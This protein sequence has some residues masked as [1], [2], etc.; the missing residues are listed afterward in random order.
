MINSEMSVAKQIFASAHEFYHLYLYFEEYDPMYQS[1][2]SIL[3]AATMDEDTTKLEDQEANAFAGQI[4]APQRSIQEQMGIYHIRRES[5][6]L[7]D[8][9]MLMEIYA[10]PYKAMVLRLFEDEIIDEEKAR[11][12]FL[13]SEEEIIHQ[14]D[15]TG[16]AKRWQRTDRDIMFGSLNE[17]IEIVSSLDAVDEEQIRHD[18]DRIR[19]IMTVISGES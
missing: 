3:D 4:L 2:G 15:L 6:E 19:E 10:I 12:F 5:V 11:M 9:L 7:K 18:S 1:H 16:R 8:I 13:V 14:C 17:N